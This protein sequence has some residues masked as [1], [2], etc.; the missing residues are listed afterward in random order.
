MRYEAALITC[1]SFYYIVWAPTG[2]KW[3]AKKKKGKEKRKKKSIPLGGVEGGVVDVRGRPYIS[4]CSCRRRD[5]PRNIYIFILIRSEMLVIF[6]MNRIRVLR[7]TK[8]VT[9]ARADARPY[10]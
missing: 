9:A 8:E 2:F 1:E 5:A 3:Q 10:S 4:L 7:L 6:L